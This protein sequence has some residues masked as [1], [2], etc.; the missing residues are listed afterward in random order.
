MELSC[1]NIDETANALRD[2]LYLYA[3]MVEE[4]GGEFGGFGHNLD[5]GSFDA[6]KFVD[7]TIELG[8]QSLPAMNLHLLHAGSGVA[9]LARLSDFWD[10]YE[11]SPRVATEDS[12]HRAPS[13]YREFQAGKFDHLPMVSS[14]VSAAFGDDYS[15]FQTSLS[16]VYKEHVVGYFQRLV[17]EA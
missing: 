9:V 13:I 1:E 4:Y 2:I 7:A 17:S 8:S 10:D 6:L 12:W 11:T 14:A 5:T 3:Q 15:A 16:A